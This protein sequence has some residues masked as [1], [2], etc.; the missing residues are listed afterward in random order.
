MEG[1]SGADVTRS[2]VAST[3]PLP[4]QDALLPP[5]TPTSPKLMREMLP[6]PMHRRTSSGSRL[7][8]ALMSGFYYHANSEPSDTSPLLAACPRLTCICRYQQLSLSHI[9]EV[10][11]SSFEFR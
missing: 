6:S 8:P 9:P 5:K 11:Q 10:S 3:R 2:P 1:R 7:G 4:G